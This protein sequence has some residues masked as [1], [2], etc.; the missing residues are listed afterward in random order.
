MTSITPRK[1]KEL[2]KQGRNIMH[3]LREQTDSDIN[4]EEIIEVAY[5]IQA[6]SYISA[7]QNKNYAEFKENYSSEIAMVISSLCDVES[8]LEAGVGEATTLSGVMQNL[9]S[10]VTAYGFDI[11]WSRTAYAEKWLQQHNLNNYK[12]CTGSLLNIPLASNSIDVVY[13]SHSI[14]PNRGM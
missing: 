12:L 9:E 13:T 7:M 2:Y 14:E 6:G 11:S 5:D 8:V 1:L 4:T 3:I 10:S